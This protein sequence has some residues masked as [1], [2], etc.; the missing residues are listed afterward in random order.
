MGRGQLARRQLADPQPGGHVVGVEARQLGGHGRRARQSPP[1]IAGTTR[2]SPSRAG[3]FASTASTGSDG[4]TTSSR[5]MFSSS[6]VWAVGAMWS[7]G[8]VGEDGVLV[9][10]VIQLAFEAGQFVVGQPEASQVGDVFDVGSGQG[11]HGSMIADR[12][13]RPAVDPGRR[14]AATE[15]PP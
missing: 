6:I 12:R 7:V 10:D 4:T 8:T 15:S 11:G 5:R 2:K 1:R 9:E 13:G 14:R 3:A